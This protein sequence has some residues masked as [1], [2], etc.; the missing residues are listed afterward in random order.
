VIVINTLNLLETLCD[1][2]LSM[3]LLLSS[4]F[5]L[6]HGVQML[7]DQIKFYMG[8]LLQIST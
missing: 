2:F 7:G 1:M 3:F 6:E 8:P 5:T 4:T